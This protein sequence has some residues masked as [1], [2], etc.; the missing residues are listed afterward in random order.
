ML[1]ELTY[2]YSLWIWAGR[3]RRGQ[4]L[5]LV[6][7]CAPGNEPQDCQLLFSSCVPPPTG[8]LDTAPMVSRDN[9]WVFFGYALVLFSL[10]VPYS[11]HRSCTLCLFSCWALPFSFLKRMFAIMLFHGVVGFLSIGYSIFPGHFSLKTGFQATGSKLHRVHQ[12]LC[13][14]FS[15]QI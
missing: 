10:L 3:S 14:K 6:K 2:Q 1:F 11:L 9:L 12:K 13:F 8:H 4:W 15:M 5:L 7:T